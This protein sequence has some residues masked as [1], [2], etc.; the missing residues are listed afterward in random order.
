MLYC[1]FMIFPVDIQRRF[2]I[3]V[4]QTHKWRCVS[5][6]LLQ[7]EHLMV[8]RAEEAMRQRITGDTTEGELS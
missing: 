4:L 8:G 6:G 5:T 2:C 1:K 3:D 7:K